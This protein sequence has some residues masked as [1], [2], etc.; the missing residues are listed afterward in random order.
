MLTTVTTCEK[1]EGREGVGRGI[2]ISLILIVTLKEQS[3]GLKVHRTEISPGS[4][5]AF[6]LHTP[7]NITL[8]AS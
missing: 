5:T 4:H 8:R 7:P 3:N 2:T 6:L 1:K